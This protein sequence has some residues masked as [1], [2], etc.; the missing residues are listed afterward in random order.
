MFAISEWPGKQR[1]IFFFTYAIMFHLMLKVI[2]NY[3]NSGSM[4]P[5]APNWFPIGLRF[6]TLRTGLDRF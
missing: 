5:G 2:N 1:F 3:G 4:N 6:G